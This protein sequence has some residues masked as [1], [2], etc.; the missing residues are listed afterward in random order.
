MHMRF[1]HWWPD[2]V[3]V[4]DLNHIKKRMQYYLDGRGTG[5]LAK[6]IQ[7]RIPARLGGLTDCFQP[8]EEI[9]KVTLGLIQYLNSIDYP[10]LIVTKSDLIA[11]EPYID[12]VRKDLAYV[13]V[14][15]TTM[16]DST[17]KQLEPR[18][19]APRER[20]EAL[21]RLNENGIYS[22]GRISPVIPGITDKDCFSV[23]DAMQRIEIPHIIFELFR[24]DAGVIRR[25]QEATR[26]TIDVLSP[27]GKISFYEQVASR[28][29]DSETLFSFCSD[30]TPIPFGI[31][32]T[33]NCCGA[34]MIG[35]AIPRTRFNTG[36]EKVASLVYWELQRKSPIE[37]SDLQSH[38]SIS[39]DRFLKA[40][41]KGD[42]ETYV[43]GCRFDKQTSQYRRA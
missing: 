38:V 5:T 30:G 35:R 41:N 31:M 4:A 28:L 17:A 1:G 6:A 33:R 21:R 23:V 11:R 19:P 27:R 3:K 8:V 7:R 18:A 26:G 32:S 20:L 40:W 13:Q 43:Y 15:V 25:V 16:N 36:N 24:G 34:D 14:T 10:Y 9:K 37:I 22:A 12:E 29:K 42:F 2:K 39:E